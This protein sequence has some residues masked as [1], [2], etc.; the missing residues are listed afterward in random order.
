M[1][2]LPKNLSAAERFEREHPQAPRVGG[3]RDA[4]SGLAAAERAHD[5]RAAVRE[6]ARHGR[7]RARLRRAPKVDERP[8]ALVPQQHHVAGL[9]V[10]VGPPRLVEVL[11]PLRYL[12]EHLQVYCV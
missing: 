8:L 5:L 3:R 4:H 11:H 10:S 7:R 12:V 2:P 9:E 6:R 1:F